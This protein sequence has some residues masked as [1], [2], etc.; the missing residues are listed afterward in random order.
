[1]IKVQDSGAVSGLGKVNEI[2]K[3]VKEGLLA[4]GVLESELMISKDIII[5]KYMGNY[6]SK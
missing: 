3:A 2:V 1:M 4:L 6:D 5:P